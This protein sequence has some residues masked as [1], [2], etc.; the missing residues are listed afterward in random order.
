MLVVVAAGRA[1]VSM[2]FAAFVI[3][4]VKVAVIELDVIDERSC[5]RALYPVMF[6]AE[7][8]SFTVS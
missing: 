6:F 4:Q 2:P 7:P 5:A 3:V 1:I 8:L